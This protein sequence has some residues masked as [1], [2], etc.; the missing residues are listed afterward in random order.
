MK[1][2]AFFNDIVYKE[3]NVNVTVILETSF[4]KEIRIA[5]KEGQ[6]MKE[7]KAPFPIVVQVLRGKIDFG[8]EGSKHQLL[9]GDIVTLEGNVKH[10]LLALEESIVRLTLS[11]GDTSN[12]V[13]NAANQ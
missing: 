3:N 9:A 12:R 6:L 1:K 2:G 8:T 13:E 10:D 11:K 7:H 5:F 4:S